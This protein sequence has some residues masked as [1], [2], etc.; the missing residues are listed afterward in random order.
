MIRVQWR[1]TLGGA[2]AAVLALVALAAPAP[3]GAV[4]VDLR[5]PGGGSTVEITDPTQSV[6]LELWVRVEGN[7]AD[8]TNDGLW[9]FY[10]AILSSNGGLLLG[11]LGDPRWHYISIPVPPYNLPTPF[12][13]SPSHLGDVVDIDHDGDTDIG[14]AVLIDNPGMAH[15]DSS[16]WMLGR[17]GQ[18][19]NTMY[20][21]EW[22]VAHYVFG[23]LV[24][25]PDPTG[26]TRVFTVAQ[27]TDNAIWNEDG[28]IG[29]GLP[30]DPEAE[31][32]PDTVAHGKITPGQEII[33]YTRAQAADP[34]GAQPVVARFEHDLTLDAGASAGSINTYR[35]DLDGDGDWDLVGGEPV[36]VLAWQDLLDLGLV[37]GEAYAARLGVAWIENPTLTEDETTFTLQVMPEPATLA[38]VALGAAALLR[39]ARRPQRR[40]LGGALAAVVALV[41]LVVPAV[42]GDVTVDLRLPGG[43]NA[44]EVTDPNLSFTVDIWIRVEGQDGDTTN[45][46]LAKVDFAVLSSNGGLVLGNLG[47]QQWHYDPIPIPPYQLLTPF[48]QAMA[49]AL[50]DRA[51]IDHDGDLDI[52]PALLIDSP[53]AAHEDG[54]H[55]MRPSAGVPQNTVYQNEWEVVH[56]IFSGIGWGPDGHDVTRV[57]TVARGSGARWN[58]DGYIGDGLLPDTE[59]E[60]MPGTL[61]DGTAMPGQEIILYARAQ[62]ADPGGGL[63]V[64]AG[65]EESLTLDA[66]DSA[67]SIN[68]YRWDLDGDGDWDLV[69]GEPVSVLAWEDLLDLGLVP[70]KGYAARLNV[71]WIENPT[72]TEDET[73]FTL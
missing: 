49:S 68:T 37:P 39:R 13:P 5:L 30:P 55:W 23:G 21:N 33:L 29:D 28:Y 6:D 56:V 7:D 18:I 54:E 59:D 60:W 36:S 41:A 44:V 34:G 47:N 4:I 70:G 2:L 15:N 67:G 14:P 16:F 73:T 65:F 19:Q 17:A 32:L 43:G 64:V 69:G 53:H 52:G 45:D 8:T 72:L 35:W 20:Q 31:W 3:G 12:S 58:E 63:P 62:A 50:G 66:G 71:A 46:G 48:G 38:L 10:C 42:R 51:D 9:K 25:G 24:W 27:D 22:L 61:T 11:D 26:V 1:R 40:T 57:F